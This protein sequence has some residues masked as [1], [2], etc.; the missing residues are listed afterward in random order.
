MKG[1]MNEL[2]KN[3]CIFEMRNELINIKWMYWWKKESMN[4]YRMMH[5][6]RKN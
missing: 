1:G 4:L 2:T 3:E 6:E 5:V